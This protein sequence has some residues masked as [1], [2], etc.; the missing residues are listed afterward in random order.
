MKKWLVAGAIM[1][2]SGCADKNPTNLKVDMYDAAGDRIGKIDLTE[3]A[4]GLELDLDLTGLPPGDHAIHF[5]EKASCK[6]PDFKSAGNHFN[7]DSK[8]HGLM[9]AEGP[10][11]GDLPNIEVDDKGKV[12]VTLQ[13]DATL[14][15]ERNT[16]L[17][18]DGTSI[19]IHEKGDNGMS[20]PAGDSGKRIACGVIKQDK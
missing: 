13:S 10:H 2:L 6:G 19:V 11:V 17:T 16:L 18:K 12:K 4:A 14:K 5:H 15:P 20:Q 8:Q 1:L 7:P 9:N 3:Q